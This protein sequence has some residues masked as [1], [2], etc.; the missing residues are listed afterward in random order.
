MTEANNAPTILNRKASHLYFVEE[1]FEVGILLVGSEVKSIRSGN[2]S[3]NEAWVDLTDKDEIWLVGAHVDEYRQ[4]S[5]FNHVPAQRRKL[6]AHGHE[7]QKMKKAK[8][9]K[10]YTLIPLKLYFK[11]RLA[12]LEVGICKGKDNKDRR[13]D[14]MAKESKREVQRIV[15]HRERA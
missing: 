4:A 12:K 10:G 6:L 13:Q 14:I 7:I 2:V 11:N 5:Q 8:E 9:L 3:L 1:R 15:K